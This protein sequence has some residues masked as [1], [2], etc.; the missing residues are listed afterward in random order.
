MSTNHEQDSETSTDNMLRNVQVWP[1]SING[2]SLVYHISDGIVCGKD[3]IDLRPQH[4]RVD[5]TILLSPLAELLMPFL[6]RYLIQITN[7]REGWRPWR[8]V[9]ESLANSAEALED[10]HG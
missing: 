5:R 9:L 2:A 8:T 6:T 4:K 10:S 3:N 7:D 1:R